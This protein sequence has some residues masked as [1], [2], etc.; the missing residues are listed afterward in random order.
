MVITFTPRT[1]A[2]PA[3]ARATTPDQAYGDLCNALHVA[4]FH[5]DNDNLKG[6]RRKLTQALAALRALDQALEG[7]Q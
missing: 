5:V 2:A 6:A 1:A 3:R 7:A 4:R